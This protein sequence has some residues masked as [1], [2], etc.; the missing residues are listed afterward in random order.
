MVP[1]SR[2]I[3]YKS[4]GAS[5][6]SAV[7]IQ[8]THVV[9]AAFDVSYY[10]SVRT[11]LPHH[12]TVSTTGGTTYQIAEIIMVMVTAVVVFVILPTLLLSFFLIF[13]PIFLTFFLVL[14]PFLVSFSMIVAVMT[15]VTMFA[16]IM[17]VM[18]KACC[19][20]FL[21]DYKQHCENQ[22]YDISSHSGTFLWLLFPGT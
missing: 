1:P 17:T 5:V 3:G 2:S 12:R 4:E 11:Y 9:V 13:I 8:I 21:R 10:I 14:G 19:C 18:V 22:G 15:V 7:R 6:T 16:P 20:Y